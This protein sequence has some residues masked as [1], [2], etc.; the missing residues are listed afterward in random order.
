[1]GDGEFEKKAIVKAVNGALPEVKFIAAEIP[2]ETPGGR[3]QVKWDENGSATALGQLPFFAGY[4]EITGVFARWVEGCPMNY[5]SP[6][7]PAGLKI[8]IPTSEC[9]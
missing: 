1:M 6:N 7:A 2:V 5:T 9:K 3:F 4:L 8:R